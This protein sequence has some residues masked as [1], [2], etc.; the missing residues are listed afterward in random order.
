M[1]VNYSPVARD[2]WR[3]KPFIDDLGL[4]V[5]SRFVAFRPR[6]CGPSLQ[7]LWALL[8]SPVANAYAY[9]FSGKRETL[10]GEWNNLPLPAISPES[11]RAIEAAA[12]RYLGAVETDQSAFMEPDVKE[13]VRP[14]LL[15]LDAEVLRLY[16][17]PP[18]LERQL[19]D[20]FTGVERKGVGCDFRGYYP[21]GLH[22][23]VPLHELVSP[24]YPR[25]TAGKLAKRF[26]PVRSKAALTALDVAEKLAAGD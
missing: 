18:R 14:A 7:V 11:S 20:L 23:Y 12:D 22:A 25:S 3:L 8:L 17:L 2:P 26:E 5:S 4:G 16:D 13:A 19:L 10:V 9:C 1:V 15:A 21:P 6:P 24:D